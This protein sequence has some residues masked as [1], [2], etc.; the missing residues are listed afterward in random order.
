MKICRPCWLLAGLMLLQAGQVPAQTGTTFVVGTYNVENWNYIER[1][2]QLNQPK[3]QVEKDAVLN[4]IASVNPDVLGLEEM[5]TTN[6][7]AELRAGLAGKGVAYPYS[8]YLQGADR[9]RRVCL[10]SR[11][12]IVARQSRADDTYRLDNQPLPISRGILDVVLQVN[13]QY[14]F[15]AIVVHLKSKRAVEHDDQAAMRLEEAKLLRAHITGI[16]KNDPA[17]KL[18][19]IGDFNDT[20][21]TAP[22]N[23]VMGEPPWALAALP[24]QTSKGYTGTHYWRF[25]GEWSRFDYLFA[26]PGMAND[27]VAGSGH[28]YE[29][30]SAGEA[31]DH[32]LVSASFTTHA[33]ARVPV[34]AKPRATTNPTHSLLFTVILLIAVL[35]AG[36][37]AIIV[38]RRH[39]LDPAS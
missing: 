26:S 35:A 12:P 5:G 8:E 21:G 19:A 29:G 30:P 18:L 10:L 38:A 34:A 13:D 17:T 14:A 25:H 20:P 3:P 31:S 15:R 2:N 4:V 36:V 27:V 24:C 39:L 32:R 1:H 23:T 16:L 9:D 33:T 11:F 6:E 37:I 28:I 7:L 22:I